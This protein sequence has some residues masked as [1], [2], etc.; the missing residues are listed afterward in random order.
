MKVSVNSIGS[1]ASI[2]SLGIG[3]AGGFLIS[4]QITLS[5]NTDQSNTATSNNTNINA[6]TNN[7]S[8]SQA[9]N[10]NQQ[11]QIVLQ[12]VIADL[13][14][15]KKRFAE[16]I[17]KSVG[18]VLDAAGHSESEIMAAAREFREKIA[19]VSLLSY[20]VDSSP[21]P[22]TLQKTITLCESSFSVAYQLDNAD[23]SQRFLINGEIYSGVP[24]MV[25]KASNESQ[26]LRMTYMEYRQT[27]K[28]AIMSY[29]CAPS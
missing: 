6:N 11:V 13:P 24:G 16:G 25:F 14:S 4:Q 12:Q 28:I 5:N 15:E 26:N 19:E 21:F 22:L 7:Q 8:V 29:E 23:Q 3:L 1:V 18:G 17:V 10:Q 20:E 9:I 2:I 27:E